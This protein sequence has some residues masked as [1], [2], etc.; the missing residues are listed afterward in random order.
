[1]KKLFI[2]LPLFIFILAACQSKSEPKET[3]GKPLEEEKDSLRVG[4]VIPGEID[5][6]GFMESGYNGLMRIEKEL[7]AEITY[8]DKIKPELKAMMDAL[9]KLAEEN[10][11]MV[12]MHGGQGSEAAQKVAEK[13]PDVQFVVTQGNVRGPNLSS[14][15]VLQ[16]ESTWLAG[17]AAGLLTESNTVGHM[18][19]IRVVPGLKGRAAFADGLKYTNP[20]AEFVTS[21]IGNQD[22]NA[23]SKKYAEAQIEKGADIIFTMLNSGRQG[24]TDA[25]KEHNLKH[26]G[27]VKDYV[28]EQPDVFIASAI[29]DSGAA[30]FLAAKNLTEGKWKPNVIEKIGLEQKDIVSLSLNSNV[31]QEVKEKINELSDKIQNK[32]IEVHIEYDGPELILEDK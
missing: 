24:V 23:L 29:A 22:D 28:A 31:P 12:I 5:D 26:I 8:I 30:G 21:F 18:S 10:P 27:N 25:L 16:E 11:D 17:A 7:G 6:K 13:Y 4:M 32:E 1:M 3:A 20:D 2:V 14:Y 19:G 9:T 15:E